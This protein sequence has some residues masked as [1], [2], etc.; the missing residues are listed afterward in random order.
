MVNQPTSFFSKDKRPKTLPEQ[1]EWSWYY[2][3]V[4]YSG[5]ILWNRGEHDRSKLKMLQIYIKK[6]DVLKIQNHKRA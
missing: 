4:C 2:L 6:R 1:A 5:Q 3:Y